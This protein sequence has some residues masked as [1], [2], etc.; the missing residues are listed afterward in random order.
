MPTALSATHTHTHTHTGSLALC[1]RRKLRLFNFSVPEIA[2]WGRGSSVIRPHSPCFY[3][4]H[5]TPPFRTLVPKANADG[6]IIKPCASHFLSTS[7][8]SQLTHAI[9][10]QAWE[11]D[12]ENLDSTEDRKWILLWRNSNCNHFDKRKIGKKHSRL[13][14]MFSKDKRLFMD[15][16]DFFFFFKQ[17]QDMS[18]LESCPSTGLC[19]SPRTERMERARCSSVRPSGSELLSFLPPRAHEHITQCTAWK[20]PAP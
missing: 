2:Q 3:P 18:P 6:M 13:L 1:R 15:W 7:C 20:C 10:W 17:R 16:A 8:C 19:L 4:A 5:H 14:G 11:G 9:T 12:K